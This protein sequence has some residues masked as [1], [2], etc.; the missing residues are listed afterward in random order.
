MPGLL[1]AC[2]SLAITIGAFVYWLGLIQRVAIAE[3]RWVINA[4]LLAGLAL[5]LAAFGHGPGTIGGILAGVSL[6]LST[7]YFGLLALAGQSTQKPVIAVGVPLPDF[8]APD[9]EGQPFT[10]SSLAGHPV[11][12]KFFRGHW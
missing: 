3:R 10:L 12:L 4:A 9:H 1:L 6:A 7:V 5:A 2:A 8:T 11:L